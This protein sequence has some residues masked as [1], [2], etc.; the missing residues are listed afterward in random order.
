LIVPPESPDV[1]VKEI[2]KLLVSEKLYKKFVTNMCR[3]INKKDDLY[4]IATKIKKLCE[5][6][7]AR[8]E[9]KTY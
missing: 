5:R 6:I 3:I 1:L 9:R 2:I 7:I 8:K 4:C